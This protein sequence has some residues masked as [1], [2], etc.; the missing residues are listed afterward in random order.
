MR[1]GQH[2]YEPNSQASKYI[3]QTLTK[4]Q[5]ET[6][7]VKSLKRHFQKTGK[8]DKVWENIEVYEDWEKT[9]LIKK[10]LL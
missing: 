5:G 2:W 10:K 7:I 1:S 9:H 6:R 8:A 3:R 4:P